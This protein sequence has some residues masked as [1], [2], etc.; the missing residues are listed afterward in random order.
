VETRGSFR[1]RSFA[2]PVITQRTGRH[3]SGGPPPIAATE[4]SRRRPERVYHQ[5][6]RANHSVLVP[7]MASV[8]PSPIPGTGSP[9]VQRAASRGPV[10]L[11]TG[12]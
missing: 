5:P 2:E 6:I 10:R 7:G 3:H 4:L 9:P 8:D 12:D 11:T 1:G